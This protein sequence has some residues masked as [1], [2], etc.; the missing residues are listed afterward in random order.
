MKST[1]RFF[2]LAFLLVE[3]M[4]AQPCTVGTAAAKL[5]VNNVEATLIASGDFWWDRNSAGYFIPKTSGTQ[6]GVATIFAGGL[7][8][9][10]FDPGGNLK[11][12]AQTY[13]ANDGDTDWWPGPLD[14]QGGIT[15]SSNCQDF[16]RLWEI[17]QAEVAAHQA[18]FEADGDIDGPIPQNILAWPG[19]SNPES[20]SANGFSLPNQELAPFVDRNGN[21]IY[22]PKAGDYPSFIGDQ[23]LWW[24]FND[25]GGGAIHNTTM[26]IPIRAEIHAMAYA[27]QGQNDENLANTTFYDFKIS[28]RA[29][30]DID[31]TYVSLWVDTDLGCHVDDHIGCLS[32]EK[33]A[34]VYND[35]NQDGQPGCTCDGGTT[36]YCENIPVTGIKVL[37]GPKNSEGEDVGFSSFVYFNNEGPYG[38]I[39]PLFDLEYY[40]FMSG[41]WRDGTPLTYGGDGY[42]TDPTAQPY[43]YVFDGN[44]ADTNAW[45]KCQEWLP[46]YESRMLISSGPFKLQPGGS[47]SITYAVMTNFNVLYPCPDITPLVEMGDEIEEVYN[48]LSPSNDVFALASATQFYPNPLTKEGKL[49]VNGGLLESVRLFNADG[50]VV[51]EY[52]DL[53]TN[54]VSIGREGLPSGF[55]C[56][57]AL[58]DNGK[59]SVGKVVVQ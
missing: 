11:T 2:I 54:E 24:V 37:N 51:R 32:S 28:N 13:G 6:L 21:G 38:A 31:S 22:E 4:A 3:K 39:E 53:K 16:N 5:D 25:E 42:N 14:P 10:G 1:L 41:S 52:L 44:P 23:A 48:T 43:P 40:R 7:W 46:A 45:S 55:Y 27:F 47:T 19:Q 49:V 58:L 56:Y 57:T 8:L 17:T 34:F 36:T 33:M 35:D 29:L 15:S 20:P 26:G 9:A 18:D 12:A 30:E 50:R 59:L